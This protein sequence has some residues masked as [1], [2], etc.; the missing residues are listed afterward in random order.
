MSAPDHQTLLDEA[1]ALEAQG[2]RLLLDGELKAAD[3]YLHDAALRYR[4][5]WEAA[6]PGA[7][8]RLV[9]MLKASILTG[10]ATAEAAYVRALDLPVESP[11]ACYALAISAVVAGDDKTARSMAQRMRAANDAFRR[12][13]EALAAIADRDPQR[14]LEAVQAIVDDFEARDEHLT[15]VRIA[16]TALMMIRLGEGRGL[17]LAVPSRLLPA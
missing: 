11:V 15:G 16:D 9:G 2:Q 12:A 1:L 5:S 7:Y 10:S 13:A 17:E 14:G 4:S 6:P 3:A 8:G